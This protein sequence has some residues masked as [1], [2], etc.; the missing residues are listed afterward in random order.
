MP[1][2]VDIVLL[3]SKLKITDSP[4]KKMKALFF[5]TIDALCYGKTMPSKR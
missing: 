4:G 2:K 3:V 1:I 5:V